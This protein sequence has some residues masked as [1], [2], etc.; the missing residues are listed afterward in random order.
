ML[1][2]LLSVAANVLGLEEVKIILAPKYALVGASLVAQLIKESARNVA[3]LGWEDCLEKGKV[4]H[5]SILAWRIPWTIQSQRVG[6][7]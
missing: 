1:T 5:A 2:R 6:Q 3:D 7:D 4:T